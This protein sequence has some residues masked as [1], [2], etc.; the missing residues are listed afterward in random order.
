MQL[1]PRPALTVDVTDPNAIA[2]LLHGA[3]APRS[4]GASA[5]TISSATESGSPGV[6]CHRPQRMEPLSAGL[7]QRAV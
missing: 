4:V 3:R 6:A 2:K 1:E 7:V 5:L